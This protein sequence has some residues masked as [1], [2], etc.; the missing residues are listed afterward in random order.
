MAKP[1]DKTESTS[2]SAAS[3]GGKKGR[4]VVIASVVLLAG[5]AGGGWFFY[6][7]QNGTATAA[8]NSEP[9]KKPTP[10][11]VPLE[12]FTVNLADREHYLQV[13]LTYEIAGGSAVDAVKQKMPVLRSRILLLLSSKTA[14]SLSSPAGKEGLARELLEEAR[15]AS[16]LPAP[17]DVISGVHFSA[18][19]IQ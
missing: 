4:M 9:A 15:K 18:F 10:T 19:V 13:G 6:S 17:G 7:Q 16:E 11:F 14:E 12:I 3:A 2:E 5:L 1:A 8:T